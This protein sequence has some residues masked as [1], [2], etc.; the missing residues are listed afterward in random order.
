[1]RNDSRAK[2]AFTI[3]KNRFSVKPSSLAVFSEERQVLFPK[4][5]KNRPARHGDVKVFF[6][7]GRYHS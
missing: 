3:N 4:E 6:K 2:L 5:G 1:V 7:D